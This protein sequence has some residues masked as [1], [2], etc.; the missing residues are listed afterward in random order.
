M[1]EDGLC[2]VLYSVVADTNAQQNPDLN[3]ELCFNGLLLVRI[4]S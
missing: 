2:Y 3:A 1:R 4:H